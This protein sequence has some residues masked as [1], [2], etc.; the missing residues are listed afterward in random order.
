MLLIIK[1]L[2]YKLVIKIHAAHSFIHLLLC[3]PVDCFAKT[4]FNCFLAFL[5]EVNLLLKFLSQS[6][7]DHLNFF[8]LM[9]K[10]I[11]LHVMKSFPF[12]VNEIQVCILCLECFVSSGLCLEKVFCDLVLWLIY[13]HLVIYS[14]TLLLKL[15]S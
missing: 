2:L 9:I 11:L 7:S 3:L 1:D 12:V 8:L 14:F 10:L 5:L 4:K 6:F 13:Q 15:L